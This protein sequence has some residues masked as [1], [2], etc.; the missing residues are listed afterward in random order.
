MTVGQETTAA[1]K[2]CGE[3]FTYR[4]KGKGRKRRYCSACK[5]RGL[6][7][8]G[9]AICDEC[10]RTFTKHRK[11]QRFCTPECSRSILRVR[12]QPK[13]DSRAFKQSF[14]FGVPR[15][16]KALFC[17]ECGSVVLRDWQISREVFC[18]NACAKT[19]YKHQRA[20]PTPRYELGSTSVQVSECGCCGKLI[21]TRNGKKFCS[22]QCRDRQAFVDQQM[23]GVCEFRY[24]HCHRCEKLFISTHG[25]IFCTDR[26]AMKMSKSRRR[27]RI[28]SNG[29]YDPDISLPKVMKKHDEKCCY[30]QTLCH[31]PTG[32][33]SS[34]EATIDHITPLARGG[35]HSWDNVHLACRRCNSRK[36]A[37]DSPPWV[38][39]SQLSKNWERCISHAAYP[40]V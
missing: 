31:L 37:A 9:T 34:C 22:R 24:A 32:L 4:K 28:R 39:P 10:G 38:T 8:C 40:G 6:L 26:C 30:C 18:D 5:S 29:P 15:K 19:Y 7:N 11:D 2:A 16:R 35:S 3:Q 36:A 13:A 12:N 25:R 33:N 17:R 1:C 23:Q 14:H 21:V 20:D 27:H